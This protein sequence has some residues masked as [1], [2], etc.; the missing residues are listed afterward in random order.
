MSLNNR[1]NII[2]LITYIFDFVGF[3]DPL[4]Y[5]EGDSGFSL[6]SDLI[7]FRMVSLISQLVDVR[8]YSEHKAHYDIYL[9]GKE[10]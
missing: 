10:I 3:Y 5:E 8:K 9:R 6:I 7:N 2:D 1:K 4:M